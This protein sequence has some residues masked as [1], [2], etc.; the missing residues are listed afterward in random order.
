VIRRV[1]AS[2]RPLTG[3]TGMDGRGISR[4]DLSS[5]GDRRRRGEDAFHDHVQLGY[6]SRLGAAA[7]SGFPIVAAGTVG[8]IVN[9]W[10]VAGLPWP[11][12]G[13]V[14]IPAL[15]GIA[16]FSMLTAPLGAKLA[17]KLPVPVLKKIFA[18][19]L[20]GTATKMMWGVFFNVSK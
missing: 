6:A 8:Y 16:I 10:S 19:F 13:Y 17:H 15:I 4:R 2:A 18:V 11:S 1:E 3:T 5:G 7:A 14:S 12:L 20:I 9:G